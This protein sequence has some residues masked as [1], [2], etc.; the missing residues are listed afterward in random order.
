M[1]DDMKKPY[2]YPFE[3]PTEEAIAMNDG[4]VEGRPMGVPSSYDRGGS[5]RWGPEQIADVHAM[6]RLGRYQI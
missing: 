5:T 1:A 4:A 2:E 6:S 3:M